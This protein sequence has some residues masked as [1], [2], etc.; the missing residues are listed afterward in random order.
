MIEFDFS[1]DA[2][3]NDEHSMEPRPARET[4]P[5]IF[6]VLSP[7]WRI[8]ALTSILTLF[9]SILWLIPP[10]LLGRIIDD[11]ILSGDTRLLAILSAVT[12]GVALTLLALSFLSDYLLSFAALKVVRR[13]HIM[14]FESLQNQSYGFFVRTDQ[15]TIVSRLWND[16]FGTQIFVHSLIRNALGSVVLFASTLIFMLVWNWQLALLSIPFLPVV[17]CVSF[18]VGRLNRKFTERVFA[19]YAEIM[20]FATSRLSIDGFIVINGF[21]YDKSADLKRFSD[22]TAELISLSVKQDMTL[23]GVSTVFNVVPVFITALIYLY[24]GTQ[25]IGG[26]TI[27]GTI[28]AFATLSVMLAERM[29]G[30]ASLIVTLIGSLALFDRIFQWI[31]LEPDV[32][33]LP[34]AQDLKDTHGHI[35]FDNVSFEYEPGAPV[36]ENLSFEIDTGELV[37]LV[38]PSGAGKTTVTYLTLRFYDPDGG[39]ITLDGRDLRDIRLA[40]LNRYTSIVPQE[41]VIFHATVKDNLLIAKPDATA[42]ELVAACK[43][44]Q[45]LALV[46]SLPE[47]YQTV[48]GEM[49][50]RLSGG[51]RQRL[52]IARA[53]LKKPRLLVMDE[54]T[55]SLDSITERAIRDALASLRRG[56]ERTTT[57]VIAHRLTTILA[58]DKILV[59]DRGRLIDSGRHS[60]LL[61]RC[62]LYRRLYEE[63]FA[64]QAAENVG[65]GV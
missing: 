16:A 17:L 6:R 61:E 51:E 64:S 21:G 52:A 1:D 9:V 40:S 50:Y 46:T 53:I 38:G 19:K 25:V 11:G 59:L 14:L 47:G 48:V 24:G 5:R 58:A 41:S 55:S 29:S 18:F 23:Q 62:D 10:A 27:L 63:Q 4:V 2:L 56:E 34:G 26:E 12:V 60:E 43:D 15:G 3:S 36:V 49:G 28:V 22:E 30:M 33:D 32:R 31:D 8:L 65:S 44:A 35:T 57:I 45:L 37:A 42:E 54:P 7:Y 13:V 39:S 20:S